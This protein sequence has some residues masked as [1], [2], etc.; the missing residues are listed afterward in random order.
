MRKRCKNLVFIYLLWIREKLNTNSQPWWKH[1]SQWETPKATHTTTKTN[2][3]W[4]CSS[5]LE[6]WFRALRPCR[7]LP[8]WWS[9]VW[10]F[11]TPLTIRRRLNSRRSRCGSKWGSASA[12]WQTSTPTR[13]WIK[14]WVCLTSSSNRLMPPRKSSSTS[15]STRLM[16]PRKSRVTRWWTRFVS[17]PCCMN[18]ELDL[19]LHDDELD[20]SSLQHHAQAV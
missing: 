7:F 13:Q 18:T 4:S 16:P 15:S 10:T 14:R 17:S 3:Q 19:D 11:V 9:D 1:P 8:T 20:S 12:R 2:N 6:P 5:V